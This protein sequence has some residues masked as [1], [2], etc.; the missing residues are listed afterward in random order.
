MLHFQ[1]DGYPYANFYSD[2]LSWEERLERMY[3]PGTWGDHITLLAAAN[4]Y[5]IKIHVIS[6]VVGSMTPIKPLTESDRNPPHE[7]K[8]GHISE[9]HYVSLIPKGTVGQ[10]VS[11]IITPFIQHIANDSMF[12]CSVVW[13]NS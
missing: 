6:S 2:S 5:K 3:Q 7:I 12:S 11:K 10:N 4:L 9:I 1:P 8:L 13:L